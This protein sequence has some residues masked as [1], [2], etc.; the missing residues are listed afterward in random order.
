M[1]YLTQIDLRNVC[2]SVCLSELG[3]DEENT[4]NQTCWYGGGEGGRHSKMSNVH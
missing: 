4:T 1:L 2:V 3:M